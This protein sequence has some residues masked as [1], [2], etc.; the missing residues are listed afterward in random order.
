MSTDPITDDRLQELEL[1]ECL[2][3]DCEPGITAEARAMA[4]ELRA[5]RKMRVTAEE[6]LQIAGL[7]RE[8][9]ANDYP[10]ACAWID[11]Y[12]AAMGEP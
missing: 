2:C 8:W 3:V 7:R 10:A 4:T 6:R 1:A 11:R 5:L 9:I 12:L